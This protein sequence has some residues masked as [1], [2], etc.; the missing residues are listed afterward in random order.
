[1]KL[2]KK[3]FENFIIGILAIAFI[4]Y[5]FGGDKKSPS[6][7]DREP[8]NEKTDNVLT[9]KEILGYQDINFGIGPKALIAL[10]KCHVNK[11]PKNGADILQMYSCSN[12]KFNNQNTTVIFFFLDNSLI[13]IG[14]VLDTSNTATTF[15]VYM[16]ALKEKYGQPEEISADEFTKFDQ[17]QSNE[18]DLTWNNGQVIL[19]VSRTNQTIVTSL[20]YSDLYYENKINN[21]AKQM[22]NNL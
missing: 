1:M 21:V 6:H 7:Q 12:F 16:K 18:A 5:V 10:K 9:T 4:F 19:R 2:I 3:L 20:M 13:R 8:S 14:L 15:G 11:L 22:K 17:G